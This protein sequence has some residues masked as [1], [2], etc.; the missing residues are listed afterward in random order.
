MRFIEL[1]EVKTGEK[2]AGNHWC[3]VSGGKTHCILYSTEIC[4][5]DHNSRTFWTDRSYGTVT[6]KKA[7]TQYE[8]HLKSLGYRQES[9]PSYVC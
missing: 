2:R 4:C 9:E 3:Y 6:T 7:C 8:N 1:S 5:V